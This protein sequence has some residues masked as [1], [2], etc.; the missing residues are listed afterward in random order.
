MLQFETNET[1]AAKIKVI[2]VG[3]GGC[4]AVN[5][6]ID[7]DLEGVSFLAVNTDKQALN[8]SKAET[9]IAIGQKLTKGLGA[10]ANPE[11]G[12][13]AAEE[14]EEDIRNFVQGAD[15]VFVTAGMGGGTGTG[16]APVIAKIA[17]D[18]GILTVGVVTKPFT[19][20]GKKRMNH[21]EVGINFLKKFVD[22]LV[23]VPNDRLLQMTE[24]HTTM[25]EAFTMA[26]QALRQGV[27]GI[28]DIIT[29][30]GEINVDFADVQSVMR[31]RGVAHMGIGRAKGEDRAEQ[32]LKMAIESPLLESKVDGAKAVLFNVAG[33]FDV[34]IMEIAEVSE[35]VK[36]LI[37]DDALF[38]L[39]TSIDESLG[40]EIEITIIATGFEDRVGGFA[41][42]QKKSGLGN[43]SEI[44][45]TQSAVEEPG[46]GIPDEFAGE[47]APATESG[48]TV[49]TTEG[50]ENGTSLSFLKGNEGPMFEDPAPTISTNFD[51]PSF[52]SKN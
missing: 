46:K 33:G 50:G 24:K 31:D 43:G 29:K 36:E 12:K 17:K 51:I 41:S 42:P 1:G 3:G 34:G 10:G 21:A 38:I 52:L 44:F 23:V 9:K 32:A 35:K 25:L 48:E 16:A 8:G 30:P 7:C 4:N 13:N 39:G 26:D 20:E 19:F 15:L 22:S 47:S 28:S 11:I 37:A 14:N 5:R 18:L 45:N 27:K 2:G 40:D 6:M 49:E